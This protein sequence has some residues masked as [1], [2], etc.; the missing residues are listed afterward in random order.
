MA[1]HQRVAVDADD[2]LTQQFFPVHQRFRQFVFRTVAGNQKHGF[3]VGLQVARLLPGD[4]QHTLAGKHLEVFEFVG[5][6]FN[7]V[8]NA[9]EC[10]LQAGDF[11]RLEQVILRRQLERAQGVL[12][13][14]RG[15]NHMR[16]FLGNPFDPFDKLQAVD[17][18]HIDVGKND[19]NFVYAQP[20]QSRFGMMEHFQ[21]HDIAFFKQ[22]TQPL[23]RQNF[24]FNNDC[25]RHNSP[26]V[27]CFRSRA[28][29]AGYPPL[30]NSL[31]PFC[32]AD[33]Q[34]YRKKAV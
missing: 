12:F 32:F 4:F 6:F 23:G 27:F 17:F 2:F 29:L 33:G 31:R 26:L 3:L 14:S 24:I 30:S 18:G 25:T 9:G 21:Q 20:F 11:N 16:L 7:I 15:K 8:L 10:G 5:T 34:K 1:H 19:I 22:N 13:V 28:M